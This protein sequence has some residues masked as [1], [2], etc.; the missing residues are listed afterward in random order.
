MIAVHCSGESGAGKT[1]STKLIL[2]Y[3]SEV[4][5]ESGVAGQEGNRINVEDAIL[6]SRS[7]RS[8][9]IKLI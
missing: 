4:S 8:F 9:L 3:L 6:Q 7:E 1:E 5:R 2:K